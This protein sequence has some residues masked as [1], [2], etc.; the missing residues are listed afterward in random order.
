MN[1]GF[2]LIEV[3]VSVVLIFILGVA[4]LQISSQNTN[5]LES[6]KKDKV[7]LHSLALHSFNEYKDLDD[8]VSLTDI[9]RYDLKISKKTSIIGTSEFE[10]KGVK[11]KYVLNKITIKLDDETKS[12]F[13]IK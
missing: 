4:L 10:F 11:I 7:Y 3:I 13:E 12:Y 8:Y 2:T 9:P 6:S 5:I 1:R